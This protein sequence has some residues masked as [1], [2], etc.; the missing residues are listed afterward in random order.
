M[1]RTTSV[2]VFGATLVALVFACRNPRYCAGNP[3][4]DCDLHW[5]AAYEDAGGCTSS[6]QCSAPTSVCDLGAMKCV[7]CV[8]P[9]QTSACTGM[10]PTCGSDDQCHA[11]SAHA[12]CASSACLPDGSCGSDG[13]VAYIDPAGSGSACTQELPC[14]QVSIALATDKPYVKVH[15]TIDEQ[16]TINS[17][18]VTLLADPGATLTSTTNGIILV[19]NGSSQVEIY[20]LTITGASGAGGY[21]ISLPGGNSAMLSLD[22]VVVSN[23]TGGGILASSGTLVA[24]QSYITGNV[25]GGISLISTQFDIENDVIA[26]NGSFTSTFGGVLISQI[27]SGTRTFLFNTVTTNGGMAGTVTGV[28]CSVVTQPITFSDDIIYANQV[29]GGGTQVGGTNCAYTYSDIGPDATAGSG[30][31]DADPQF[32]DATHGDFDI[33]ATSPC[34]DTADPAATEP[35]DIHGTKRPQGSNYDMGADEVKQ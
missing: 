5:D 29:S 3:D 17:Q 34:K 12:D 7:A 14:A 1:W 4:N 32:V 8:A 22:R 28:E 20:D 6:T 23:N 10:T 9:D 25:A 35:V 13:N 30:N 2:F 15:G 26:Q 16:V 19:V 31:I 27:S 11:C 24:K 21:G 18:N 33:T